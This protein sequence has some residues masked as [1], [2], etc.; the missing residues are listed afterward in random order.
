MAPT[1]CDRPSDPEPAVDAFV[2]GDDAGVLSDVAEPFSLA[3]AATSLPAS[4]VFFSGFE[5]SPS[6]EVL[7]RLSVR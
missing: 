4:A 5:P 1:F 6:G 7:T 2:A 3:L